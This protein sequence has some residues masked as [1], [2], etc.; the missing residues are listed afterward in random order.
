MRHNG[1]T[2]RLNTYGGPGRRI[3]TGYVRTLPGGPILT[4]ERTWYVAGEVSCDS[5]FYGMQC[6]SIETGHGFFLS[7]QRVRTW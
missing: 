6:E 5:S 7:R 1:A 4:Y 3:A 2:V